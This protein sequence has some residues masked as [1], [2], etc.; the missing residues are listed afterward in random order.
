[1]EFVGQKQQDRWVVE[2]VFGV[3]HQGY[4]VDLAATD[5][6]TLNN[7]VVLERE[8]GWKGIAIEANPT[9]FERLCR[10]RRCCCVHACVDE[11]ERV[12]DFLPNEELGGIVDGDTDNSRG[13]RATLIDEW[14]RERKILSVRTRTLA[15]ILDEAGAPP[16]IDYLSLDIEGAETRVLRR[17]P[18]ERRR[19]LTLTIERPTPELNELLFLNGYVFVRNQQFDTFY[20]HESLPRLGQLRREPFS[21][22]P[23]KDW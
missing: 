14:A 11:C 5:G 23:P 18:F 22:V 7:T 3:R 16:F 20:V 10:N 13:I 4:F 12:V 1:M 2:E 6:V 15:A 19:F 17:F 8:L 21:Q 9:H